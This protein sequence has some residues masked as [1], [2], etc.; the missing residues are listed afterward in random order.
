MKIQKLPAATLVS[1]LLILSNCGPKTVTYL[2]SPEIT[3]SSQWG[4]NKKPNL[5][6]PWNLVDSDLTTAWCEGKDGDYGAGETIR[7]TLAQPVQVHYIGINNGWNKD[8]SSWKN[9]AKLKSFVL[10]TI[11]K[12]KDGKIKDTNSQKL[13]FEKGKLG[14]L[15]S[16]KLG[17]PA[18]ATEIEIK[19]DTFYAVP[20]DKYYDTCLSEVKIGGAGQAWYEIKGKVPETTSNK[21]VQEADQAGEMSAQTAEL[22]FKKYPYLRCNYGG[23]CDA[24][25][26]NI[27][28]SGKVDQ[29]WEFAG[30]GDRCTVSGSLIQNGD[31][32]TMDIQAKARNQNGGS[33]CSGGRQGSGQVL[34]SNSMEFPDGTKC[35]L[36]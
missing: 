10:K 30:G 24:E 2:D 8:A 9:N 35:R 20:D 28:N 33:I 19:L 27:S 14:S 25:T 1:A 29:T 7:I 15:E 6:K 12:D 16:V 21:T 26:V 32:F 3:A 4:L 34:S 23:C 13:S 22:D 17:N 5:F 18:F 36:K 31:T 11:L